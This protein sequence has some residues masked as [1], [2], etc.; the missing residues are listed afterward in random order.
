MTSEGIWEDPPGY[1]DKIVWPN[2]VEDHQW[3]FELG[4][5]D[6]RL[7][8]EKLQESGVEVQTDK[9]PDLEMETSLKWAVETLMRDLAN[10]V[11]E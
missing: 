2:Y 5:V 4:D 6:G 11:V 8:E 7:K 10:L 9:G 3:M 1:F